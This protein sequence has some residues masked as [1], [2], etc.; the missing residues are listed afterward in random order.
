MGLMS[1]DAMNI[2]IIEASGTD[3]ERMYA[4]AIAPIIKRR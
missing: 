2:A 1:F 4:K 3:T